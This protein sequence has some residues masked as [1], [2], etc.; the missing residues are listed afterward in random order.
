MIIKHRKICA[1]KR[2]NKRRITSSSSYNYRLLSR[3]VSDCDYYLGY[4]NRNP[5]HLW[6]GNVEDQI[7]E[8]HKLYNKLDP[9]PD[10]LSEEDINNYEAEMLED[11]NSCN[12]VISSCKDKKKVKSHT[13]IPKLT[14]SASD[15]QDDLDHPYQ[16][17]TS[18]NTSINSKKLPAIYKLVDFYPGDVVLDYGGGKFDNAVNYLADKDVTL[19]V[20]DPYNR[21]AEHNKEVLSFLRQNGGAD[22]T[23]CSNVLNVIKEPEARLAVL[24]NIKKLTKSSGAIYITVYEGSGN[25]NAGPTKSG[26]QLNKKIA[27]YLDEIQEVFPD[28]VRKG[29][30]IQATN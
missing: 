19:L 4:G 29:K 26:Y 11:V 12:N 22:A 3:L 27:E 5:K 13:I 16:E 7:A 10:W 30:L 14:I 17:Y 2:T 6:A 25:S 1:S 20:Y 21:S 15:E 28:A 8:M 24:K 23:V 9:K 18:E